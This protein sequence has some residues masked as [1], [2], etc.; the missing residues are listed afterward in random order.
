[1]GI[2]TIQDGALQEGMTLREAREGK[3]QNYAVGG[4]VVDPGVIQQGMLVAGEP[5]PGGL[6]E[7]LFRTS[8]GRARSPA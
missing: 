4:P 3:L 1:M 7:G 2:A 5:G 8:R 6:R